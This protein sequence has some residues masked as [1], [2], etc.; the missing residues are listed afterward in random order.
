M[1]HRDC[2]L[3]LRRRGRIPPDQLQIAQTQAKAMIRPAIMAEGN[4]AVC[5]KCGRFVQ[6]ATANR[7]PLALSAAVITTPALNKTQNCISKNFLQNDRNAP[8]MS[9][10]RH[11]HIGGFFM[12]T[13]DSTA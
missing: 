13:S 3:A 11:L 10:A 5:C 9:G 4:E 8:P 2:P 7:F 6:V 12:D 1:L